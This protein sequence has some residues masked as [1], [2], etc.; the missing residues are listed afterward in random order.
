MLNPEFQPPHRQYKFETT[1]TIVYDPLRPGMKR[2]THKWAIIKTCPGIT[3]YYR[4]QLQSRFHMTVHQPA[5]GSHVSIVRGEDTKLARKYWKHLDGKKVKLVY[6]HDIF[7]NEEHAWVNVHCDE[8][9]EI[10]EMMK[11]PTDWGAHLT[12]GRFADHE[13][14]NLPQ[15]G[16][17]N[18]FFK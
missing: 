9:F 14:G 16:G 2:K 17:V 10:R 8:F 5:W 12:I 13:V 7:W 1:G 15:H 3:E 6:T 4:S 11:L 18:T